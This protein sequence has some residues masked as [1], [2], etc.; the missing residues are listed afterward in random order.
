[1]A[2]VSCMHMYIVTCPLCSSL[3]CMSMHALYLQHPGVLLLV[4]CQSNLNVAAC[5]YKWR[6]C[7]LIEGA[8]VWSIPRFSHH[9]DSASA[10]VSML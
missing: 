7:Q 2:K 8:H 3:F 4:L 10:G 5:V 6:H 9:G 1:M